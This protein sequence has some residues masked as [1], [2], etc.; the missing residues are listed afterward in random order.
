MSEL[1]RL[2]S[3]NPFAV[4]V[5]AYPHTKNQAYTYFHSWDIADL[6]F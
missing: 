2:V 5:D 6:S 1:T 3:M 4:F